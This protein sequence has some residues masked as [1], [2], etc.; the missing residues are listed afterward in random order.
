M[1]PTVL[2]LSTRIGG[3]GAARAANSLHLGMLREGVTSDLISAHGIGFRIASELDRILWR[4]QSSPVD[5]WR[6]PARF[7][8][9]NARHINESAADVVNLHWVT[10]GFLSI[11][12]IGRITK[13]VVWSMYDMWP[14]TGTEHYGIDA[15][16]ARWR[17]GY[18]GGNR[19]DDESGLDLDRTTW[20]RK[21][22]H[23]TPM[24]M[25]PASTWL[26]DATGA[27]ELMRSWPITRIPHVVDDLSFAPMPHIEARLQLGL[28]PSVPYVV[29]VASAGITDTRKGFD[30]LEQA[31]PAVKTAVTDVELMIVGPPGSDRPTIG[32]VPVRWLGSVSGDQALR[33]AY[34]AGAVIAVPSREDNM[35]LTAME[36][37]TCGRAVVGFDI[38]GLPDIVDSGRT[39]F[40]ASPFD[41]ED[42]SRGLIRAI[43]DSIGSDNWGTAARNRAQAVWSPSA[44]VPQYLDLYRGVLS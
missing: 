32:G 35:P 7:G 9:L 14:F 16:T 4:L 31:L 11:E 42:L 22:Q 39:G 20:N 36:A 37:Q 1:P 19:P 6:S 24:H 18:T 40:L 23:W 5:T 34:S 12:E 3:G 28:E 10:D 43:D 29:F 17:T 41:V 38:G 2:H 44:V 30:L 33:T 27:S 15:P 8:S 21:Q 26:A 13:P 25:V